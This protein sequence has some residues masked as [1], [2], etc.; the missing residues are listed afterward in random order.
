M[1]FVI[2]GLVAAWAVA[3]GWGTDLQALLLTIVGGVLLFVGILLLAGATILGIPAWIVAGIIVIIVFAIAWI[4]RKR[5]E[6]WAGLQAFGSLLW[7]GGEA[8]VSGITW[9]AGVVWA[10]ISW[11]FVKLFELGMWIG[12]KVLDGLSWVKGVLDEAVAA[13]AAAPN[14]M[15]DRI[16]AALGSVGASIY[17]KLYDIFS[18][19]IPGLTI[20]G[21]VLWEDRFVELLPPIT[22]F[23]KGGIV[24]SP[25]LGLIGEAGPEAVIPLGKGGGMGNTFNINIDVSGM[26]DRSDKRAFAM[27]ISDEIQ[28]EMRRY[29]RG[30]TR[31][32]Y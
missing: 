13:V 22:A 25:T 14:N 16:M 9:L 7:S 24:T 31:R 6:I 23:A 21:K 15:R 11:P 3:S 19:T 10:I 8:L 4:W 1:A 12:N 17:N 27:Q 18:F 2:G 29:G 20:A 30:T 26:T 28:R 32:G 5:D